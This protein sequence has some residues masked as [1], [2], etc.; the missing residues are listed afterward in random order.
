MRSKFENVINQTYSSR[1]GSVKNNFLND[2]KGVLLRLKGAP[3]GLRQFLT[4]ESPLK[5]MENAF[6]FTSKALYFLKIFKFL[7]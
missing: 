3:S 6:Y 1:N 7:S 5:M 4:N 2:F